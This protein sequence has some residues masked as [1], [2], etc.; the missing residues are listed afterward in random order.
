MTSDDILLFLARALVFH[1]ELG[2]QFSHYLVLSPHITYNRIINEADQSL[3][4]NIFLEI[5]KRLQEGE[6]ITLQKNQGRNEQRSKGTQV[7]KAGKLFTGISAGQQLQAIQF[8]KCLLKKER[9]EKSFRK[10]NT[11]GTLSKANQNAAWGLYFKSKG[12]FFIFCMKSRKRK[13]S[14]INK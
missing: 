9:K 8:Y 14:E 7:L 2:P 12:S 10:I 6:N 13:E 3:Q 1:T 4:D 11:V 5:Q